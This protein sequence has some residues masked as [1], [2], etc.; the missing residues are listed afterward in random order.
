LADD[1]LPF[2]P[3]AIDLVTGAVSLLSDVVGGVVEGFNDLNELLREYGILSEDT[4]TIT[5]KNR[6]AFKKFDDVILSLRDN[7]QRFLSDIRA[8][9]EHLNAPVRGADL[10]NPGRRAGGGP[11][12]SSR[13]FLVGEMGPEIFTPAAGGGNITANNQ[14][15]GSVFNITVN[16][17]MGAGDGARMGEQIVSAIK[18][19]ERSSG[20]V[21]VSA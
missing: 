4:P 18:R 11:V 6:S 3:G 8:P 17:G 10:L 7:F 15:G 16:A 12:S 9:F 1:V 5:E 14:L 13:S 21:F 20:K 19:F 2:L